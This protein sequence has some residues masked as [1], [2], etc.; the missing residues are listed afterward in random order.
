MDCHELLALLR[1][2]RRRCDWMLVVTRIS[3]LALGDSRDQVLSP[4]VLLLDSYGRS[5]ITSHFSFLFS[6]SSRHLCFLV[7][8]SFWLP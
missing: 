4:M 2:V 7:L 1:P 8:L 3:A 5:P 6:L